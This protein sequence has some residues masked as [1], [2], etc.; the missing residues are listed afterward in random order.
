MRPYAR[1]LREASR[2]AQFVFSDTQAQPFVCRACRH[3][4]ASSAQNGQRAAR[5]PSVTVNALA[6]I[7]PPRSDARKF[8]TTLDEPHSVDTAVTRNFESH[9][10][11]L[12]TAELKRRLERFRDLLSQPDSD[13][14]VQLDIWNEFSA[15]CETPITRSILRHQDVRKVF[16]MI[17]RNIETIPGVEEKLQQLQELV[18]ETGWAPL[19]LYIKNATIPPAR[20][21][22]TVNRAKAF[23][24]EVQAE[25]LKPNEDTYHL[26]MD[27]LGSRGDG[28]GAMEI[29]HLMQADG[30]ALDAEAFQH[31]IVGYA[32]SERTRHIT[33]TFR[34]MRERGVGPSV[35]NYNTAIAAFVKAHEEADASRWYGAMV[36]RGLKPDLITFNV[37][38]GMYMQQHQMESAQQVFH[39]IEQAGLTPGADT[40]NTMIR[41]FMQLKR[42]Q[43]AIAVYEQ[44]ESLGCKP[45]KFTYAALMKGCGRAGMMMN[46]M[47]YYRAML[48][49]GISMNRNHYTILQAAFASAKDMQTCQEVLRDMM[50]QFPPSTINYNIML[51]GWIR[52]GNIDKAVA[53]LDQMTLAGCEPDATT[54][55]RLI[56]GY[57]QAG[58]LKEAL[59]VY[60]KLEAMKDGPTIG[61]YIH[62]MDAC[63]KA[64]KRDMALALLP[65]L[66]DALVKGSTV[67]PYAV[68]ERLAISYLQK[69]DTVNADVWTARLEE[70]GHHPRQYLYSQLI[71]AAALAREPQT[72]FVFAERMKSQHPPVP[73]NVYVFN[74]LLLACEQTPEMISSVLKEMAV[75]GCAY[76]HATY[77][78]LIYLRSK[79]QGKFDAS[80]KVWEE[81]AALAGKTIRSAAPTGIPS[82][83]S[84]VKMH[85]SVVRTALRACAVRNEM[86]KLRSVRETAAGAGIN[87]T[88]ADVAIVVGGVKVPKLA[89]EVGAILVFW[90]CS[91]PSMFCLMSAEVADESSAHAAAVKASVTCYSGPQ[92]GEAVH[93]GLLSVLGGSDNLLGL[94]KRKNVVAHKYATLAKNFTITFQVCPDL[95]KI[96]VKAPPGKDA[97]TDQHLGRIYVKQTDDI[98]SGSCLTITNPQ[99]ATTAS[100]PNVY[101]KVDKCSS[102]TKPSA[103]QIF[104]HG[105]V[106][107]GD[108]DFL[109]WVGDKKTPC[110]NY[111]FGWKTSG[112]PHYDI[113]TNKPGRAQLECMKNPKATSLQYYNPNN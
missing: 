49:S 72:A 25:G 40:Y 34:Y 79:T 2:A 19:E 24:A 107:N 17:C 95:G 16:R 18:K 60:A 4:L 30:F 62:L 108:S 8:G 53:V 90:E 71:R 32:R 64:D 39:E 80:W 10:L 56:R 81:Y 37:L 100:K 89:Q 103:D 109:L 5:S 78:T 68:Y 55:R 11:S 50:S 57:L 41:G 75:A 99:N 3:R 21:T 54:W 106:D 31:V 51:A 112:S 69:G 65:R 61:T 102:D 35:R 58:R 48:R 70:E 36:L 20:A 28:D 42:V 67:V 113:V 22:F 59:D 43:D 85:T 63:L 44:M 84:P 9:G 15:I 6:P 26:L 46:A 77:A 86:D 73:V 14:A 52:C 13:P 23:L 76:N 92:D 98:P 12:T 104:S 38:L 94:D 1:P 45:D 66:E 27:A 105:F 83:P 110:H 101:L 7:P 87:L 29:L 88:P 111:G 96:T 93:T 74:H 33:A 91:R 47:R 97:Y 82:A